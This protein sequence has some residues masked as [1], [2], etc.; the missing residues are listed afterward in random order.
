M[1]PALDQIDL[2]TL[3]REAVSGFAVSAYARG[4]DFSAHIDNR[5]PSRV[6]GDAEAL[7]RFLRRGLARTI[8]AGHSGEIALAL[9]LDDT[10]ADTGRAGADKA[11]VLLEVCRA[12]PEG[13]R[14]LAGLAGL[15]ALPI[16]G[17]KTQPAV[18][19]QS[20]GADTVLIPIPLKPDPKAPLIVQ[21]WGGCFCGCYIL[22]MGSVLFDR[23]RFRASLA[24]AGLEVTFTTT[25]AKALEQVGVNAL[26]VAPHALAD[27]RGDRGERVLGSL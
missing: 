26:A 18:G 1:P 19:R 7:S 8:E 20:N 5:L 21:K 22:H 16:G 24:A 11:G 17:G 25:P 10:G 27:G 12:L 14:R 13:D 15:W 2:E 9:W 3:V 4:I 6:M 23:E